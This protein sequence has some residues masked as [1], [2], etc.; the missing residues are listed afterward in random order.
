MIVLLKVG[1]ETVAVL[2]DPTEEKVEGVKGA[3]KA[4][5]PDERITVKEVVK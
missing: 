5:W 3:L 1:G 4:L 2:V